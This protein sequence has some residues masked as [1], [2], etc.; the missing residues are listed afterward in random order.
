MNRTRTLCST[1]KDDSNRH[2]IESL[3]FPFPPKSIFFNQRS[4]LKTPIPC[5]SPQPQT[6]FINSSNSSSLSHPP[7]PLRF[8]TIFCSSFSFCSAT[9]PKMSFSWSSLTFCRICPVRASIM[10]LFSMS[11][12]RLSLTRRIRPRRSAASGVRICERI[13]A[14]WSAVGC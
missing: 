11:V 7:P 10:S 8:T 4:H 6:S 9:A 5:F 1:D 13:E 3:I 12:A 2:A 14:R